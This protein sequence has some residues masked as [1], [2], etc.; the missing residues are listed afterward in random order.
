MT[1][2]TA[3]ELGNVQ[4]T[5][6]LPLWGRAVETE[7]A[8]PLLKDETA[9]RIIH[10]VDYDFSRLAQTVHDITRFEWIVRC[11]HIDR[12]I[13]A[14]L[15]KHPEGTI[16]NV[17]S[18]LDTTFDRVDN[19]TLTWYDLDLPD[20]IDLRRKFIHENDRSRFIACSF[21][22]ESWFREIRVKE[23]IL[24]M[25]AGVLYYLEE[26]QLKAMMKK[27]ASAF[28]GGEFVF[29]A[30]SA[31]GV[32]TAN[33]QLI[34]KIGLDESSYLKWAIQRADQLRG[35][36]VEFEFIEEYPMF[37]HM[38]KGLTL[39]NKLIATLSDHYKM[40]YMIHLKFGS[41]FPSHND[42]H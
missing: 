9:V 8:K 10:Q 13:R 15:A 33:E 16:V 6:L 4:I 37:K 34:K 26:G 35:W 24:F 7:K 28:P 5:L 20:V 41:R 1:A 29:D 30:C 31:V 2:K 14:F 23:N 18:G 32:K 19:G 36:G 12:T 21:L 27:M 3:I 42:L 17:G 38:K 25:A 40:M 22:D 39:R 11:I